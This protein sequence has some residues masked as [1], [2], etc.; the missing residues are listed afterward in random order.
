MDFG[1]K[2]KHNF[3][4]GQKSEPNH[5][6]RCMRTKEEAIAEQVAIGVPCD[7]HNCV[8]VKSIIDAIEQAKISQFCINCGQRFFSIEDKYCIN[9]GSKK[10]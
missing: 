3:E 8:F 5:C 7:D 6:S 9:C 2:K 1:Y 10:Y 4:F